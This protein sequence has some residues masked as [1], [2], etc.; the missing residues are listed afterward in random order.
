M[1]ELDKKDLASERH[2]MNV[3]ALD[4]RRH[5]RRKEERRNVIHIE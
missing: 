4:H 1:Q 2:E 5:K 3:N